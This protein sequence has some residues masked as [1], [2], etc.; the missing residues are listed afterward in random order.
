[1][2]ISAGMLSSRIRTSATIQPTA[3]PTAIPPITL[4]TKS[5]PPSKSEK[6]PVTTAVTATP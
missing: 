5:R 4:T 3:R 6:L 1:M 2:A